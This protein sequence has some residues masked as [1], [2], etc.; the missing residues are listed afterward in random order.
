[1]KVAA[2]DLGTNTFLCLIAEGDK[3]GIRK[4]HHDL[5][6]VVRLGQGVDKTG[7]LHIEALSRA[8]ECLIEFKKVIDSENVHEVLA[9]ATSAARDAK[10]GEDLFRIGRELDIPIQVIPGESEARIS[11]FGALGG[12]TDQAITNLVVDIGGG[13]TEL[14]LGRGEDILFSESLNIGGVRLTEKFISNQPVCLNEINQMSEYIKTQLNN[15]ALELRKNP[16]DRIIA[17]AGTPTSIAS[18][19]VGGFDEQKVNGYK[20]SKERLNFWV[21]E[22][23]QTSVE[24]KQ[25][26]Y[27]LGGR[28]DII[29]AGSSILLALL[30][31]LNKDDLIVSTKGVRYGVALEMLRSHIGT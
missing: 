22:F 7:L 23:A 21:N 28:A 3:N 30:E 27:H 25:S 10:N 31:A 16:I 14:I 9:M 8:K 26:R 1:M 11:Y 17:V 15:I 19:E 18:I 2:L 12:K 5:V 6:K 4:V 20:L 29:F 13:S 24:E